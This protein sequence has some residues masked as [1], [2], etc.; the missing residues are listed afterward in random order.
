MT[1][2]IVCFTTCP[3]V[4][5]VDPPNGFSHMSVS[6]KLITICPLSLRHDCLRLLEDWRL[7]ESC[8]ESKTPVP[9][10][11]VSG[12]LHGIHA[13]NSDVLPG[14]SFS[15]FYHHPCIPIEN[16][17][18]LKYRVKGGEIM[19]HGRKT[20]PNHDSQIHTPHMH[21]QTLVDTI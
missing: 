15:L 2:G 12:A 10:F 6:L 17:K 1:A 3:P 18:C 14:A 16:R 20:S 7:N 8:L 21:G 13:L 11:C 4:R 9:T 19:K 5:A